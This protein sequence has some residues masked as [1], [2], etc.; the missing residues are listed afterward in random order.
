MVAILHN[1]LADILQGL[2]FPLRISDMLP[3][4]NLGK[5]QQ[6]D[7]ITAINKILRLWVM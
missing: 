4:R 6:S 3:S 2:L 7:F 5:Y 1:H